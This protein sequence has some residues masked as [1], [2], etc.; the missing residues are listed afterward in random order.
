MPSWTDALR[1]TNGELSARGV[2]ARRVTGLRME[3]TGHQ[4]SMDDPWWM[5]H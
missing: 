5:S 2:P 4:R 1:L 3:L